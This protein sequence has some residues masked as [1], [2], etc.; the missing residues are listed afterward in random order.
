MVAWRGRMANASTR[1][2]CLTLEYSVN[3]MELVRLRVVFAYPWEYTFYS[4][5]HLSGGFFFACKICIS[6]RLKD[7]PRPDLWRASPISL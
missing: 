5:P 1:A 3:C 7:Q 6:Q 2:L 4:K